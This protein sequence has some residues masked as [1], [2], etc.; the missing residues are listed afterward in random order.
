MNWNLKNAEGDVVYVGPR[1][2]CQLEAYRL[3]VIWWISE[4]QDYW[5]GMG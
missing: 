1:E 2:E 5:L 3:G 4:K